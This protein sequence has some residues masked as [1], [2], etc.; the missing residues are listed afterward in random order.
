MNRTR[1]SSTPRVI[2]VVSC[3]LL[4]IT[5]LAAPTLARLASDDHD[6]TVE[7]APTSAVPDPP[8][9]EQVVVTVLA[10]GDLQD[11]L[12]V[13]ANPRVDATDVV[14][15]LVH[16]EPGGVI[17][18]HTHPGVVV[19]TVVGE[20]VFTVIHAEHCHKSPYA[21]GETFV[22]RAD[23]IHTGRNDSAYPL[24][25]YVSFV[26]PDGADPTTLEPPE[27]EACGL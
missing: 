8:V 17:D 23:M 6:T 13:R 22:E 11:R 4:L 20:G 5:V 12:R 14:T 1:I 21:D 9:D 26:I 7:S 15:A 16:M 2:A 25:L 24:D 27:Y 18:W 19:G 3:A 10:R